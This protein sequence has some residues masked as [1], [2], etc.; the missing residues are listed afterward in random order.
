M[1]LG[2]IMTMMAAVPVM[3]HPDKCYQVNWSNCSDPA[4]DRHDDITGIWV[5]DSCTLFITG[6]QINTKYVDGYGQVHRVASY[7]QFTYE[8]NIFYVVKD[9]T[10]EL[11]D[12]AYELYNDQLHIWTSYM[13]P[14]DDGGIL[15]GE[16]D[17]RFRRAEAGRD[18][19]GIGTLEQTTPQNHPKYL[20]PESSSRYLTEADIAGFSLQELSYA[21]NEIAAKHGRKFK[22]RELTEYFSTRSWYTPTLDIDTY[23]EQLDYILNEYEIRNA[24]WLY[25]QEKNY[26]H[27]DG[28]V[29]DQPGYNI[30]AVRY[31]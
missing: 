21:R 14:Y 12:F 9:G 10:K 20:L 25:D 7:A 1:M 17:A 3:A 24:D 23:S 31:Y 29:L 6:T 4:I 18:F 5:N 30:S 2:T 15:G 13:N 11:Y 16:T 28:Y 8:G 26:L 27:P 22:S 19:R